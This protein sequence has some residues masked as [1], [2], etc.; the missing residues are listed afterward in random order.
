LLP[1]GYLFDVTFASATQVSATLFNLTGNVDFASSGSATYNV[2]SGSTLIVSAGDT[3][4]GG[5][6]GGGSEYVYAGGISN[7]ATVSGGGV[8]AVWFGGTAK[9]TTVHSGG[10]VYIGSGGVA[11]GAT[12]S[13]GGSQTVESGGTASCTTIEGGTLEVNGGAVISG[14]I[15]FAGGSGILRIDDLA[16]APGGVQQTFQLADFRL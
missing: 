2:P 14:D 11:V 3:A 1:E 12:I 16:S 4:S 8:E 9:D 13:S 7:S 15:A 6:V 10:N 5:L